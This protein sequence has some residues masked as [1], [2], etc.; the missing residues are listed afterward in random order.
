MGMH[1]AS[2][3]DTAPRM[4]RALRLMF[5]PALLALLA[6]LACCSGA[7]VATPTS[8]QPAGSGTDRPLAAKIDQ[9][10]DNYATHIIEIQ[11]SNTGPDT[12]TVIAASIRT[13][14]FSG[15]V[16]WMPA[17]EGTAI[18]PGQTK[19]LPARLPSPECSAAE[20][21]TDASASAKQQT[22]A[23]PHQALLEFR[24][25]GSPSAETVPI[26]DPFGVLARNN[27]ELC[28][29]SDV[30]AIIHFEFSPGLTR[31]P[32][33]GTAILTLAYLPQGKDGDVTVESIRG[34][35]LITEDPDHPWPKE[36]VLNGMG[37]AG[38]IALI[39]RP[40]RCDPHA[41]AD[42]KVGTLLPLSVSTGSRSGTIKVAADTALKGAIQDFVSAVC[43]GG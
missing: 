10:R 27:A 5:V 18:P 43:R 39:I 33:T 30:A 6:A 20:A 8:G 34:T 35:T 41:V 2:P 11:V 12:V 23:P 38:Q 32:G 42:D 7:P 1:D 9:F 19:S 17:P 24:V 40:A 28:L 25:A 15:P 36:T 22:S 3:M 37:A 26:D 21:A 16:P 13:G 31:I 29:A 14:L 4:D